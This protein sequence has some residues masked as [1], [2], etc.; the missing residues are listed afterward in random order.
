MTAKKL[1]PHR[2]TH[3]FV[4]KTVLLSAA[5]FSALGVIAAQTAV[6]GKPFVVPEANTTGQEGWTKVEVTFDLDEI[7]KEIW[8]E[9]NETIFLLDGDAELQADVRIEWW[10]SKKD[11]NQN[12]YTIYRPD[13]TTKNIAGNQNAEI[14]ISAGDN[15][16]NLGFDFSES[17]GKPVFSNFRNSE[18]DKNSPDIYI[19]HFIFDGKEGKINLVTRN[20]KITETNSGDSQAKIGLSLVNKR[21]WITFDDSASLISDFYFDYSNQN[22][23]A[24]TPEYIAAGIYTAF[25][26]TKA[27]I[28]NSIYKEDSF[29]WQDKVDLTKY[30]LIEFK[31][32]SVVSVTATDKV[33][34]N[35]A[36]EPFIL[37]E[38]FGV[39]S[40][41]GGSVV[42]HDGADILVKGRDSHRLVS[43]IVASSTL[44][45]LDPLKQ[46]NIVVYTDNASNKTTR[47][48]SWSDDYTGKDPY[49]VGN[50]NASLSDAEFYQQLDDALETYLQNAT[51]RVQNLRRQLFRHMVQR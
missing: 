34:D 8:T 40:N 4:R 16:F 7:N 13:G 2:T 50:A 42:F 5:M 39:F 30:G 45:V 31:K 1:I 26:A 47:I 15:P 23:E 43:A 9:N 10:Q 38:A 29:E 46:G 21:G 36:E 24:G 32:H 19:K 20:S 12:Y 6:A 17:Q 27:N 48:W 11:P 33:D 22:P 44:G 18:I 51:E 41:E 25:G 14:V 35:D 28:F 3:R 49:V 37:N